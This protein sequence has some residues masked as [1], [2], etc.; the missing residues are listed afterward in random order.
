VFLC[1]AAFFFQGV[2]PDTGMLLESGPVGGKRFCLPAEKFLEAFA[3]NMA[4]IGIDNLHIPLLF[5]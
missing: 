2:F 5:L 1:G 3:G 4:Q